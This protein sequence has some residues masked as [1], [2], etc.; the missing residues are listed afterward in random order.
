[1][2]QTEE[3]AQPNGS[4]MW[5]L[6]RCWSWCSWCPGRAQRRAGCCNMLPAKFPA[7]SFALRRIWN[8]CLWPQTQSG[9]APQGDGLL[10]VPGALLRPPSS[11]LTKSRFRYCQSQTICSSSSLSCFYP[12]VRAISSCRDIFI[13][14]WTASSCALK[15]KTDFTTFREAFLTLPLGVKCVPFFCAHVTWTYLF[16]LCGPD[17]P[18]CLPATFGRASG[19]RAACNR[20]PCIS[21]ALS[22][23]HAVNKSLDDYV[24]LNLQG[25]C[26]V[27]WLTHA[28]NWSKDLS[29]A[30]AVWASL[31]SLWS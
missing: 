27:T 4:S 8:I 13:C 7:S 5:R 16:T 23:G 14:L 25:E 18:I 6:W 12:F 11:S 2:T 10:W 30:F 17:L 19:G 22:H 3:H 29:P 26:C 28:C 20:L 1:M 9:H 15:L 24:G 21:Q 31:Q